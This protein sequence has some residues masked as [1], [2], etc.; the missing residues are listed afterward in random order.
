MRRVL[1]LVINVAAPFAKSQFPTVN[2]IREQRW[3]DLHG[4]HRKP[5]VMIY[6]GRLLRQLL[7]ELAFEIVV[8]LHRVIEDGKTIV[9]RS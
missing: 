4:P 6:L 5:C 7:V 1:F 8:V 9:V 2:I 3:L